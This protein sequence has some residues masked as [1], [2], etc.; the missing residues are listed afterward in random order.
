MRVDGKRQRLEYAHCAYGA[1][2]HTCRIN[3][4]TDHSAIIAIVIII[5]TIVAGIVVIVIMLAGNMGSL[6]GGFSRDE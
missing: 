1:Y 4:R 2:I 3:S 6:L 5:V